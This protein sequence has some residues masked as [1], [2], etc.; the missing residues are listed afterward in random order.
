MYVYMSNIERLVQILY[1][2]DLVLSID[3]S[4]ILDYKVRM[5]RCMLST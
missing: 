2:R 3:P 4:H 1:N 5:F